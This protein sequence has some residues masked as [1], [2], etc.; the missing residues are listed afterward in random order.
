AV[1]AEGAMMVTRYVPD[2]GVQVPPLLDWRPG[3]PCDEESLLLVLALS[4]LTQILLVLYVGFAFLQPCSLRRRQLNEWQR[5]RYAK[6]IFRRLLVQL[7]EALPGGKKVQTI[8]GEERLERCLRVSE[9]VARAVQLFRR[10]A[11]KVLH[12]R[13]DMSSQLASEMYFVLEEEEQEVANTD[14][15]VEVTEELLMSLLYPER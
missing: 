5:R 9:Q 1:G 6:F 7:E 2:A 12:P 3:P 11:L 10:D 15:P 4:I 14:T 8:P 13:Q